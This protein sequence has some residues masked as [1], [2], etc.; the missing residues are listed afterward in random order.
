ML[1]EL[2]KKR[3]L[4]DKKILLLKCFVIRKTAIHLPN[5]VKQ[6]NTRIKWLAKI[7]F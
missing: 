7:E 4:Y 3:L 6:F 5:S 2:F 1:H